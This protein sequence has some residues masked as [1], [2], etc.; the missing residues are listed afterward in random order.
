MGGWRCCSRRVEGGPLSQRDPL[1]RQVQHRSGQ[2]HGGSGWTR[3][4][5]GTPFPTPCLS[6]FSYTCPQNLNI[7][8][9]DLFIQVRVL[10]D[11][12]KVALEDGSI[13]DL[14]EGKR[15]YLKR[16]EAEPLIRQGVLGML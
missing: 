9:K 2:L 8:P 13:L 10:R 4:Y 5:C 3:P 14:T 16:S 7:P 12:G 11:A 1:L 6:I 15:A